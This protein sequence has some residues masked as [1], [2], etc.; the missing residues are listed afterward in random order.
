MMERVSPA[1]LKLFSSFSSCD[2]AW[3]SALSDQLSLRSAPAKTVLLNLGSTDR[4]ELFLVEGTLVLE[5]RDGR[6]SVIK[7]GSES[8]ALPIARL[9]PSIYRVVAL[10][11]VRFLWVAPNLLRPAQE[12]EPAM[13]VEFTA[14]TA[15]ELA[16]IEVQ[17]DA[18][19]GSLYFDIHEDLKN[20]A[21]ALPTLPAV[22][23]RIREMIDSEQSNAEMVAK[24]AASDPAIAAKLLRISNS[25]LYRGQSHFETLTQAIVRLGMQSTKQ[26]VTSFA[27]RELFTSDQPLLKQRLMAL[28]QHSVEV[29]ATCFV[30]ARLNRGLNPE[31][32][33]LTG[34]LHD[35]GVL[36]IISHAEHYPD[37]IAT[38][39]RLESVIHEFG[40]RVSV[41]IL[42][43]WDF[44]AAMVEACQKCESWSADNGAQLTYADLVALAQVHLL[45]GH[46]DYPQLPDIQTLP[47]YRKLSNQ[48]L[49]SAG[50]LKILDEASEQVDEA[51]QLLLA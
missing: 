46:P 31:Q 23:L 10:T 34:L 40:R 39:E 29:A 30:L 33:L 16:R 42:Q 41:L 44:P 6:K 21:L 50:L 9:R 47:A 24:A 8:A 35:I 28:W 20:D 45:R 26:I 25:P 22:A 11:P 13:Q 7:S 49:T 5:A 36:A 37:I 27:V 15:N 14:Q 4:G 48:G 32:A 3:L 18:T 19:T 43:K 51:R 2:D 17:E 38:P 12:P 1:Q